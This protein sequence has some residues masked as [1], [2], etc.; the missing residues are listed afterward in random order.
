MLPAHTHGKIV[1]GELFFF[2]SIL[3]KLQPK[4]IYICLI[5]T[6]QVEKSS[7]DKIDGNV[8]K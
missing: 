4:T 7:F 5:D 8:K 3:N 6:R 2:R 1:L